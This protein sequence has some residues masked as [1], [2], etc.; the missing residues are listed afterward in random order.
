[1]DLLVVS[2]RLRDDGQ[3]GPLRRV[4]G[5]GAVALHRL[6]EGLSCRSRSHLGFADPAAGQ[7]HG[8]TPILRVERVHR[9]RQR[10]VGL[11]LTGRI[12]RRCAGWSVQRK[13]LP[14]THWTQVVQQHAGL[15][16]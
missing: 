10:R 14:R 9:P 8:A 13:R 11:L 16:I 2:R 12:R 7:P 1:M 6:G 5:R 15:S 3:V 4:A